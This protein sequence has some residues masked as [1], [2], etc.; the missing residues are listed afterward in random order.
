M[1]GT[2]FNTYL[3]IIKLQI[4]LKT[5]LFLKRIVVLIKLLLLW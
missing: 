2:N 1:S 3:I 5:A 4:K